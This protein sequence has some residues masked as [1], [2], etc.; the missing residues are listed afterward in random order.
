[1][2]A[3]RDPTISSL[4]DKEDSS[5]MENAADRQAPDGFT[6]EEE[7]AAEKKLLRKIDLFLLPTIWIVYLLSY[8]VRNA[9]VFHL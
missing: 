2:D 1:M 6:F 9:F 5:V 4:K 8:M 7:T 3:E